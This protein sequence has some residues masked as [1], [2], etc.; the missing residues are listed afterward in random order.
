MRDAGGKDVFEGGSLSVRGWK[1]AHIRQTT[2]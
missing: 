1:L 2:I